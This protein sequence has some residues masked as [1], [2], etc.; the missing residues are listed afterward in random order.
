MDELRK[1]LLLA[2]AVV[3]LLACWL[4]SELRYLV[5]SGGWSS[6]DKCARAPV[7]RTW[8]RSAACLRECFLFC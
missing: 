8:R 4:S 1:A 7:G 2:L 3:V 5:R 6:T